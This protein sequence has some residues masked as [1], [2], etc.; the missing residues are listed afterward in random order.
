MV[1]ERLY[2]DCV[3]VNYLVMLPYYIIF[4]RS[5]IAGNWVKGTWDLPVSF[6]TIAHESTIIS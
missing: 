1:K 4:V 5:Y 3:N 2:L 6:L